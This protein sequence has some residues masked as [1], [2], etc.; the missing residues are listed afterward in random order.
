M[1]INERLVSVALLI[2]H[3]GPSLGGLK[4][5]ETALITRVLMTCVELEAKEW[6]GKT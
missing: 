3:S 1:Q 5:R 4:A 6:S 2:P